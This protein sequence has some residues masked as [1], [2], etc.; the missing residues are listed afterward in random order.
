MTKPSVRVSF[1]LVSGFMLTAYALAVDA[2]RLANWREGRRLFQWDVRTPDDL[3]AE[4]SNGMI[5]PPDVPLNAAPLPE[6]VFICA[7]FSAELAFTKTV[8]SWL[9][10]LERRKVILGG[11]DTGPLVLAEAGL[12]DG[13]RMAV[14]W[15]ALPAIEGRYPRIRA[16]RPDSQISKR[17]YTG[18]GGISTFDLIIRFIEE[19][20]GQ[21]VARMVEKSANR[22][23]LVPAPDGVR[24]APLLTAAS[25]GILQRATR[26]MERTLENPLAI[27]ALAEKCRISERELHRLFKAQLGSSPHRFYLGLRLERACDLLRQSNL[28]VSEIALLTGFKSLS[29]FSQA[30]RKLYGATA[31]DLRQRPSWLNIAQKTRTTQRLVKTDI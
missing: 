23:I 24:A 21:N 20:A 4:A 25:S 9:R 18:P 13:Y 22:E 3:P 31:T 6:A 1:L 11:W 28:P 7:G 10:K 30:F 19:E 26:L 2:L 8:F 14:H 15:Q 17:R 27:P 29:R 5:I 12:M 16:I